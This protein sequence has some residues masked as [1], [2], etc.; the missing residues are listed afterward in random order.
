[1]SYRPVDGIPLDFGYW[2]ISDELIMFSRSWV[3]SQGHSKVICLSDFLLRSKVSNV[4]PWASKYR[5]FSVVFNWKMC[6]VCQTV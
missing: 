5:L 4:G 2:C 3:Q 1:M 6:I